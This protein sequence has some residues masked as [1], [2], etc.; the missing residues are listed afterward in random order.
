MTDPAASSPFAGLRAF[1]HAIDN[2]L[3][4]VGNV[5]GHVDKLVDDVT[6]DS[7]AVAQESEA[8]YRAATAR[9]G[10]VRD[11]IRS[12]PRF[13]RIVSEGVRIVA[14]YRVHRARVEVA[15]EEAC[16]DALARLHERSAE[17]MYQMCVDMRGGVL[18]LGQFVS[19]RVDLLPQAYIDSLGRLQ[20]QVPPVP[21]EDIAARIEAELGAPLAELFAEIEEEPLA[22]AS[23]AQVHGAVTHDGTRVAVKVQVPGIEDIIEVDMAALR[24]L[25]AIVKDLLPGTDMNTVA[26]ELSRS[27]HEE[28]DFSIEAEHAAGFRA[29]FADDPAIVVPTVVPALSSRRVLTLERIDGARLIDYLDGCEQRGEAGARDRDFLL[30]TM[31]GAF[32]T[33][34][35]DHGVFHADP[36]PGNFLVVTDEDGGAPRLCMLDYGSVQIYPADTRRAYIELAAAILANDAARTS[37]L[38]HDLGFATLDGDPEALRAFAD[39][40]LDVFRETASTVDLAN[41]DPKAELARAMKLAQEH[42]IATIPQDFVMLGRVF[43]SLGGMVLRYKPRINLFGLIAPHLAAA[44]T[45]TAA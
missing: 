15:G 41:I 37:A 2:A 23:L 20:D 22:A 25:A 33:Q 5:L 14:A 31:I 32:C 21:F 28:L 16:A 42:P 9:A 10:S 27:V 40:F 30:S 19:A 8:L 17:R 26:K 35:L 6:R 18:K 7:R 39:V 36:H 1:G 13:W 45:K 11:A 43:A 12:T 3:S 29:R 4:L 34:V 24:V 44:M 38:L